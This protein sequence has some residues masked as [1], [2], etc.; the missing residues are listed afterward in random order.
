ML[1]L[2]LTE[3]LEKQTGNSVKVNLLA[4]DE[5]EDE[6]VLVEETLG[7]NLYI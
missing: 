4:V 1:T 7:E 5:A 6:D 3:T 2:P